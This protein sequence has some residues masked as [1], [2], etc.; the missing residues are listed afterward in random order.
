MREQ[1][2]VRG[3]HTFSVTSRS[4]PVLSTR[5]GSRAVLGAVGMGRGSWVTPSCVAAAGGLLR[6]VGLYAASDAL[7]LTKVPLAVFL[8]CALAA[9]AAV[10]ALLQWPW[11]PNKKDRL[12]HRGVAVHG[13][14]LACAMWLFCYGLKHCG[15]VRAILV[16]A[17]QVALV[18]AVVVPLRTVVWRSDEHSQWRGGLA[19]VVVALVLLLGTHGAHPHR[20][21]R[22]PP[23]LATEAQ[24]DEWWWWPN[25][26]MGEAALLAASVLMALHQRM[27]RPLARDVG[28]PRRLF[29]LTTAAAAAF[30]VPVAVWQLLCSSA[31]ERSRYFAAASAWRCMLFAVLGLAGSH[32]AQVT[33]VSLSAPSAAVASLAAAYLAACVLDWYVT[34]AA[35]HQQRLCCPRTSNAYVALACRLPCHTPWLPCHTPCL[36]CHTPCLPSSSACL[37]PHA[38]PTTGPAR[39]TPLAHT[40]GLPPGACCSARAASS[41][42]PRAALTAARMRGYICCPTAGPRSRHAKRSAGGLPSPAP[43]PSAGARAAA[44][45]LA[46]NALP[47]CAPRSPRRSSGGWLLSC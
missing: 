42:S 36:L 15:P 14:M 43:M 2:T 9:T 41:P 37:R 47:L 4:N 46:C 16:E 5:L 28:G 40:R 24:P 23:P 27:V 35:S 30:L 8:V 33:S 6:S 3:C 29:T 22:D 44:A 31:P 18:A 21:R 7:V 11:P 13:V 45:L 1:A 34:S 38:L 39:S 25:H 17:S 20:S 12:M 26:L 32:R 10:S 19:L